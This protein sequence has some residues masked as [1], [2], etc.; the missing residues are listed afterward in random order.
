[1]SISTWKW[2]KSVLSARLNT[3]I[4]GIFGWYSTDHV[5]SSKL[6]WLFWQTNLTFFSFWNVIFGMLCKYH[7]YLL[8]LFFRFVGKRTKSMAR[9]RE[10]HWKKKKKICAN[11]W[12][13]CLTTSDWFEM[14][15]FVAVAAVFVVFF[16][17]SHSHTERIHEFICTLIYTE[18]PATTMR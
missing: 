10:R 13:D 9:D 8:Q 15:G 18:H 2:N 7:H 6:H 14:W 3:H 5:D 11:T 16:L 12:N 1:M 17:F 4:I